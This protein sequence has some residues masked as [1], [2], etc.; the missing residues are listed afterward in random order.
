METRKYIIVRGTADE[1]EETVNT[2]LEQGYVI[3]GNIVLHGSGIYQVMI[4][5]FDV[6]E[7]GT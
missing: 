1:I 5:A 7:T 3:H 2:Y 6:Q 4:R